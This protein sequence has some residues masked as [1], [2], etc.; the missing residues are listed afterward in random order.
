LTP[1]EDIAQRAEI[2]LNQCSILREPTPIVKQESGFQETIDLTSVAES[3]LS[4]VAKYSPTSVT[5]KGFDDDDEEFIAENVDD[6]IAGLVSCD[7]KAPYS[8]S[9]RRRNQDNAKRGCWGG[10]WI[11]SCVR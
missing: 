8:P 10:C 2:I 11:G 9:F 1:E 6:E 5:K 3:S 4:S 7:I